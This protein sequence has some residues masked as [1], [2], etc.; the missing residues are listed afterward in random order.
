MIKKKVKILHFK[1]GNLYWT[2]ILPNYTV[3]ELL[4]LFQREHERSTQNATRDFVLYTGVDN[5]FNDIVN[6]YATMTTTIDNTEGNLRF[7]GADIVEG[8]DNSIS[9]RYAFE[10]KRSLQHINVDFSITTSGTNTTF[11][12]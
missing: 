5:M 6:E 2:P 7:M 4:E 1:S 8:T 10:P 3:S 12:I 9:L 11:I